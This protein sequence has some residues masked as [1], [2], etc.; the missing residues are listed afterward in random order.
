MMLHD[1]GLYK[2]AILSLSL[3]LPLTSHPIALEVGPFKSS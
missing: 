1:S 2:F 3:V